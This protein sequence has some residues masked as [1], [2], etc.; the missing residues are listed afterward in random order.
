M[1]VELPFTEEDVADVRKIRDLLSAAAIGSPALSTGVVLEARAL[2]DGVVD[3][4]ERREAVA[5]KQ[6]TKATAEVR[7]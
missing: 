3:R 1:F 2:A 7:S 5:H 6:A 4:F